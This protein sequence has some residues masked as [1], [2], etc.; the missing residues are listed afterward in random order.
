MKTNEKKIAA[1]LAAIEM[2]LEEE[3]AAAKE[4]PG[5]APAIL[6]IAAPGLWA[7]ASNLETMAARRMLQ[8]RA[9]TRLH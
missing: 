3:A 1:A 2:Y 5:L 7:Q 8:L 4:D 6:P 9:F